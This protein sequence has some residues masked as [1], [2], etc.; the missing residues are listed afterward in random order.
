VGELADE[1]VDLA[2]REGRRD[3]AL[4]IAPDEEVRIF[5]ARCLGVYVSGD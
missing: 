4:E 3:V 2:Q 5:S 1:R